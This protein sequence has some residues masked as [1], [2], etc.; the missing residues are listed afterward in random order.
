MLYKY[1]KRTCDFCRRF[2]C[3]ILFQSSFLF[4]G[5]IFNKTIIPL[6]LAGYEMIIA[7]PGENPHRI[8][9]DL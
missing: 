9:E 7:N 3:H 5:G 1:G 2:Y 8:F 4:F 6:M